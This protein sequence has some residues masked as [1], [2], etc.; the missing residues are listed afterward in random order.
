M[1]WPRGLPGVTGLGSGG[2]AGAPGLDHVNGHSSLV[3]EEDR[4]STLKKDSGCV[5]HSLSFWLA[6]LAGLGGH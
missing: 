6:N 4:S 5:G 1:N 3:G 2:F